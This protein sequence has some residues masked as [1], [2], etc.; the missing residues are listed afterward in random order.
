L[1]DQVKRLLLVLLFGTLAYAIA[2]ASAATIGTVTGGGL[3]AGNAAVT[4]CDATGLDTAYTSA[5]TTNVGYT[6]STLNVS[7]FDAP[8]NGKTIQVTVAKSD[9]TAPSSGSG[10]VSGGAA[11]RRPGEGLRPSIAVTTPPPASGVAQIFAEVG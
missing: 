9:G 6:V 11:R 8:C 2:F 1:E 10:T 5:Y 3:G 7:S 4:S